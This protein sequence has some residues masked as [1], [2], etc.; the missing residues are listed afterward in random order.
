MRNLKDKILNLVKKA[1]SDRIIPFKLSKDATSELDGLFS[2]HL[3][4][5]VRHESYFPTFLVF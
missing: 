1:N 5:N 4:L 2:T 3:M